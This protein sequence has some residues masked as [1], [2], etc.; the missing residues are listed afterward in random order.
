MA[1]FLDDPVVLDEPLTSLELELT[2]VDAGDAASFDFLWVNVLFADGTRLYEPTNRLIGRPPGRGESERY[3]LGIPDGVARRLGDVD[4]VF[5][6]KSGDEGWFVGSVLLFGN[7]HATPVLGNRH[8]NQFLDSDDDVLGLR[9]WSSSS[10]CVA[11]ATAAQHPLPRSGYRILGPVIGQ[12]S[13]TTADVL[14]RVDREGTYRFLATDAGTGAVA[15]DVI[16]DLEPTASFPL[17]DLRPDRRYDFR[18][19][20]VRAGTARTVPGGSGS[21]ST[22]PADGTNGRFALA[23]GSCANPNEQVAQGSW[24]A[25]RSLVRAPPAGI[26]PVRLFVHLGDTFYFY[27]HMTEEVVRNEETMHAAHASMRRNLEFLRLARTVPCCGVW[28]DHDF[29]S[30]DTDST[31]ISTEIRSLA[32]DTWKRYWGNRQPIS[33]RHDHGLTTRITHGLVD[34]YLLD[35]RFH[36]NKGDGICFG[37]DM[38]EDLL[39]TIADRSRRQARVVVLATG[40]PWNNLLDGDEEFYGHPAYDDERHR[41]YVGLGV[42]MGRS[43]AGL[44]LLSGDEHINEIFHVQLGNGRMAP[45]FMSTPLTDNDPTSGARPVEGERVAS[46]PS[47]GDGA[48]RG[49]ATLTID[50][51]DPEPDGNWTATVRYYQEAAATMYHER[52]YTLADGQFVPA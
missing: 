26:E 35:G 43:I 8:A 9:E 16:A 40:S 34:I 20:F 7:G 10:F 48:R 19:D 22:Y 12:V 1:D 29:A 46:F 17:R 51:T 49:F 25:I 27:D 30:D 18:L 44:L 14:Y 23:F 28:D 13:D 47:E 41:L 24:T 33:V 38:V 11:P 15:A 36:R 5:V 37:G 31:D 50:T 4:E 21:L 6:R 39:R 45:E 32:V 42:L 3:E 2:T 52:S